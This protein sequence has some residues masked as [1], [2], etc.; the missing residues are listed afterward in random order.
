MINMWNRK[1]KTDRKPR[2][3][4]VK[5]TKTDRKSNNGNRHSTN[6]NNKSEFLMLLKSNTNDYN[7]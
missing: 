3:L 7:Y 2:F 5:M 6:N 1:N 4:F